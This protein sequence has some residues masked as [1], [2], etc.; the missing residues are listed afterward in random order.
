MRSLTQTDL[1]KTREI[2]EVSDAPLAMQMLVSEPVL[3]SLIC[4]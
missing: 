1:S 2:S 3:V 4:S